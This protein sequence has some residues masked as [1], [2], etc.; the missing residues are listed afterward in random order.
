MILYRYCRFRVGNNAESTTRRCGFCGVDFAGDDLPRAGRDD[1]T[2]QG[3][4]GDPSWDG[5]GSSSRRRAHSSLLTFWEAASDAS[6]RQAT[7]AQ[8][9]AL[10]GAVA[11]PL[12]GLSPTLGIGF[13][14]ALPVSLR[15]PV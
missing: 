6:R 7:L 13:T 12:L 5:L 3:T 8:P 9:G 2:I 1:C 14:D 15:E 4:A 10:G 11:Y